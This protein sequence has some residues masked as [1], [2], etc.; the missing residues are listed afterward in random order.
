[1]KDGISSLTKTFYLE[2]SRAFSQL[3]PVGD[4]HVFMP[5]KNLAQCVV[6]FEALKISPK[7]ISPIIILGSIL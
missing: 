4:F 1:M 6:F 2:K 3:K 7:A 5:I